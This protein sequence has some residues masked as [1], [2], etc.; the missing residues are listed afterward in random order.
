M[1]ETNFF[2]CILKRKWV[3]ESSSYIIKK[4]SLTL[5]GRSHASF[6]RERDHHE[7]MMKRLQFAD[8]HWAGWSFKQTQMASIVF[9]VDQLANSIT[10]K[11]LRDSSHNK[12]SG[13][14]KSI[15]FAHKFICSYSVSVF[16]HWPHVAVDSNYSYV[17]G[18]NNQTDVI[19]RCVFLR[20]K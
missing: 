10:L 18:T 2:S 16:D 1:E 12:R 4:G 20:F 9:D 5:M 17:V 19:F 3:P 15:F 7:K 11:S 13:S 6:R 14:H 8:W